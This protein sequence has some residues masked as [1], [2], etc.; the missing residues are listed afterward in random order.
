MTAFKKNSIMNFWLDSKCVSDN[1]GCFA[2][3]GTISTIS[4]TEDSSIGVFHVFKIEQMLPNRAMNHIYTWTGHA[5]PSPSAQIVCPSIC[6]LISWIKSTTTNRNCINNPTLKNGI[7]VKTNKPHVNVSLTTS[8]IFTINRLLYEPFQEIYLIWF[9]KGNELYY[10]KL[11]TILAIPKFFLHLS[12]GD[13][14]EYFQA[15]F[16]SRQ[17]SSKMSLLNFNF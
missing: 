2:R 3:F 1:M 14:T 4:T 10:T 9:N 11:Q 8:T 13:T 6:L 12:R 5:A 7:A 17:S 15:I 16:P